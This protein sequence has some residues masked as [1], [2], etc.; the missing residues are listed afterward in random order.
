MGTG[1]VLLNSGIDELSNP[2]LRDANAAPRINGRRVR[3]A[4]P[5]PVLVATAR[6]ERSRIAAFAHSFSRASL[7]EEGR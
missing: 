1:L 3:P 5:T 4:D 7:V 6:P 2:R